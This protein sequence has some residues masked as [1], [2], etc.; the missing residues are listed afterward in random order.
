[1]TPQDKKLLFW[2]IVVVVIAIAASTQSC[3]PVV[4]PELEDPNA[5]KSETQE[6]VGNVIDREIGRSISDIIPEH[7]CYPGLTGICWVCMT[8]KIQRCSP[9][10]STV[11]TTGG[12]GF[13]NPVSMPG[14][15]NNNQK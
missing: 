6:M 12:W 4:E 15:P 9:Q 11:T 1:M 3:S 2:L 14:M 7:Y 10:D 13:L 5:P 8:W